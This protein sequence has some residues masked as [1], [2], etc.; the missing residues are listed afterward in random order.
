[1]SELPGTPGR[2][3][4]DGRRHKS[5]VPEQVASPTRERT[6]AAATMYGSGEVPP[7]GGSA[8]ACLCRA[9]QRPTDA[10]QSAASAAGPSKARDDGGR[11]WLERKV[12]EDVVREHEA[13]ALQ[14]RSGWDCERERFGQLPRA[15]ADARSPGFTRGCG[16]G[17]R[18]GRQPGEAELPV[19]RSTSMARLSL[20]EALSTTSTTF[21]CDTEGRRWFRSTPA[22][23][24][25]Q[26]SL[27]GVKG[28]AETRRTLS[29]SRRATVFARSASGLVRRTP[30]EVLMRL[31]R[32]PKRREEAARPAGS[33]Q[34]EAPER[35]AR[36]ANGEVDEVSRR[37]IDP[38]GGSRQTSK[39]WRP[40]V[41]E[42]RLSESRGPRC[43]RGRRRRRRQLPGGY[44]RSGR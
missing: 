42:P 40:K 23:D 11:V 8:L 7:T 39:V 2:R 37:L 4:S 26:G 24:G 29:D 27:Q 31:S 18:F 14:V 17:T 25:S 1:M 41:F 10:C 38:H 13:D 15:V 5:A 6:A 28:G 43:G 22:S 32:W 35:T 34:A 30:A 44:R 19:L 16:P 3:L 20:D 36:Q 33:C 12:I 9:T 21:D